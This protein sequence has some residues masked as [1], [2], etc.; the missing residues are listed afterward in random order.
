MIGVY[1]EEEIIFVNKSDLQKKSLILCVSY[2][3]PFYIVKNTMERALLLFWLQFAIPAFCQN[4]PFYNKLDSSMIILSTSEI[5]K[6]MQ[7]LDV[8]RNGNMYLTWEQNKMM[9]I[10]KAGAQDSVMILP[11]GGHGDCFS[12]DYRNTDTDDCLF[13][14]I[15]SLGE[16]LSNGGFL[17]GLSTD[18]F[19]K[20]ICKYKYEPG[21]VKYPEDAIECYYLNDNGC[22]IV[23]VDDR[24]DVL[25]CWTVIEEQDWF[26]LYKLSE[27][28]DCKKIKMIVGREYNKGKVF[29]VSDLNSITPIAS[30]PWNRD[31]A[32]GTKSGFPKAV[33]GLCVGNGKIYVLCG[34]KEDAAST[35]SI[36]DF[37]GNILCPC[38]P[39][40]V[41]EDKTLLKQYGLS[42]DGSFE[43]EGIHMHNNS[44]YMGFVGDFPSDIVKKHSCIIRIGK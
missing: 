7:G 36:I 21:V 22:R 13:W 40:K 35:V 2:E 37:A 28:S 6:T 20:L 31:I 34:Y 4:N 10:K 14:G 41:S 1:L 32:C 5:S 26:V 30:F 8:D 27:L 3:F 17:G 11:V 33:Q 15:G 12:I 25:L 23:D 42:E 24:N 29:D 9:Y 16:P 18:P 38:T 39:I 43:P 19:A 44:I